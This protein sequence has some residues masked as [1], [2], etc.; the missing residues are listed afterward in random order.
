MRSDRPFKRILHYYITSSHGAQKPSKHHAIPG[1][2]II[3]SV[4]FEDDDD[5]A[6]AATA[7]DDG[8]EEHITH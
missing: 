5:E 1:K 4:G 6:S 3:H 7:I 2:A 8:D